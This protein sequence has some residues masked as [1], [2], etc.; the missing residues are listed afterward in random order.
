MGKV[1]EPLCLYNYAT[2]DYVNL[3]MGKMGSQ[4][5]V[6]QKW[7][8]GERRSV[9]SDLQVAYTV[10]VTTPLMMRKSIGQYSHFLF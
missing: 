9:F 6:M 2:E 10:A 7:F 3:S 8:Q 1:K 4:P 5:E